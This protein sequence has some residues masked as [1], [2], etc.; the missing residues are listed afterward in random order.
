MVTIPIRKEGDILQKILVLNG[1]NLNQLGIREPSVYGT[2]TLEDL[3]KGLSSFA[4]EL[5]CEVVCK[6]S[7]HEGDLIDWIHNANGRFDGII[8]N[9]GAFTHYSYAIRDAV[10]GSP[11]PVIEV[12]LSNIHSR[13]PF[14]HQSVISA[15]TIGQIVG[16]GFFGYK[17]AVRALLEN[18]SVND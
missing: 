11:L 4:H 12:H 6:Q 7:N 15:E 16:F 9:P 2:E 18:R 1:P 17:L 14:R 13:E 5:N 8:I 3:E 10:A